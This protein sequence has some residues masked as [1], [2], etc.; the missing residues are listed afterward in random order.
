MNAMRRGVVLTQTLPASPPISSMSF[1]R[2]C[3]SVAAAVSCIHA[4]ISSASSSKKYSD[5][6]SPEGEAER[7]ARGEVL[8]RA[9][10]RE[11][12]H[13]LDHADALGHRDRAARVER[14]EDVRALQREVVAGE[15]EVRVEAAA[16]LR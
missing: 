4:G 14:V 5:I 13:A 16:C 6:G 8:L 15:H 1:V 2:R 7:L 9:A 12:A 11:V 10:D 3:V